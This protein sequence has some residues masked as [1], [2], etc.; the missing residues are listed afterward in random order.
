MI[1]WKRIENDVQDIIEEDLDLDS[2]L[3][4]ICRYL[5]EN[6]EHYDWVG[7]YLVD[8]HKKDELVLGPFDGEPTIHTRIKF[9]EGICGQAAVTRK[10][11]IVDDVSKETN[12]LA[13]SPKVKS[14]IVVPIFKQ[15][16]IV[17]EIDID[18]HQKEAFTEKDRHV[19][20]NIANLL[21]DL[22]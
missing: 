21:G 16:K 1:D 4:K 10:V 12:Y 11:F 17:G 2:R 15:G 18:S 9:G 3:E 13:C 19:L 14:E 8:P 5:R 22:F 20:E 7:F 6:V